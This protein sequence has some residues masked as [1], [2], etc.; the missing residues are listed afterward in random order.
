[1]KKI[2]IAVIVLA[3][4]VAGLVAYRSGWL[5]R[6][7][8]GGSGPSTTEGAAGGAGGTIAGGGI[9][10]GADAGAGGIAG[11]GAGPAPGEPPLLAVETLAPGGNIALLDAGAVVESVTSEHGV[12]YA[13]PF[14]LD[15]VAS[16]AW[17]SRNLQL[18]Q[19]IVISFFNRQSALIS[20]VVANPG[21]KDSYVDQFAKDVEVWVSTT[22]PADGFTKVGEISLRKESADQ[23]LS[24]APVEARFVKLRILSNHGDKRYVQ[25]SDFKV[26]E[27]ERPGYTPLLA[28]NPE[29]VAL[30]SGRL[31]RVPLPPVATPP[32]AAAGVTPGAEAGCA[33]LQASARPVPNRPE[34]RNVLVIAMRGQ[35]SY[36]TPTDYGPTDKKGRVDY[37]IYGRIRFVVLPPQLARPAQLPSFD[38]VVLAQLCDRRYQLT[39]PF[40]K[41]LAAWAGQ[42]HKLI[43][44]DSD[45]C[46]G[47][48]MPDY[49]FLPF[50]FAT[51]NPGA[52][53][54]R[55]PTLFFVE[56]NHLVNNRPD[57]PAFLDVESWL[58]SKNGSDNEIGDSNTVTRYDARWCG[59]LFGT[60][61]LK[62]NGFMLAYA[63][64]GRGLIIYDGF[65]EDQRD[66]AAYRQ[67]VTRELALGFDPDGL[68]CDARLG[69]FVITTEQ[70]LKAQPMVP[71][72]TYTYPLT[73]YSNQG[74]KGTVTLALTPSPA[75]PGLTGAFEPAAVP[76]EEISKATLTVTASPTTSSR[77]HSLAVRGTDAAGRSNALCLQLTERTTGGIQVVSEL[78]RDKKPTRNLEIILDVS[79][80][81][82]A[83]LG[84]KTRWDTALDVL[85]QVLEK[86]PDDFHVGLRLYGH[87]EASTSAKTCTDT[88][89]VVPIGKL[90]RSKILGAARKWK[91][92]GETPLV[93]SVLQTP[94][95]LKA[96]GGG[97]V[98]LITDG[99][100][101]CKGDVKSAAQQIRASGLDVAVNIVGFTLTGK[102]TAAQLTT[103]AE[104]TG[105]HYYAAQS[106]EALAR[107]LLI[108]AVEKFP[109]VITDAAGKVVAKGEAGGPVE[110][111]AA[112][113]YTVA[114]TAGDQQLIEKVT[115]AGG[116]DVTLRVRL[117]GDKFVV[118][119]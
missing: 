45:E 13:A 90:N 71:G 18:P 49:G 88:E 57:D 68:P 59:Q 98:I 24:L 5:M 17:S 108:A 110:E 15:G 25:C 87:R 35:A 20:A 86:L 107:A 26:I 58:A 11:G 62:V 118:Q 41:A 10:A 93:Y 50:P 100:E 53:G 97:A 72:R 89:L 85:E 42:G 44:Q 64:Y 61:V 105:G 103:L 48:N 111:L 106:G 22:G 37:S 117:Q 60:N 3:V 113:E 73:L 116:A 21:P 51:S 19:D 109:Y 7:G 84:K 30:A 82:K 99:E 38:T 46:S 63:H 119:R 32:A 95:D 33:P 102:Q 2:V 52:K 43:I 69:D 12:A 27:A 78:R 23:T 96:A 39:E 76:L 47:S 94:E 54:A 1:M 36:Y 8:A 6:L 66:G 114:V 112:G 74:Y 4:V 65:D 31:P 9:T 77:A 16:T 75:E 70:R 80:S 101:S 28:R 104:G 55:G 67:L 115:V 56:E 83:A 79:G 91:P 29:V 34:S 14:V 40:K 81:M 92:K